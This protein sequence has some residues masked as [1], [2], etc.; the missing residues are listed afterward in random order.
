MY[1]HIYVYGTYVFHIMHPALVVCDAI[2]PH[3]IDI[4]K[5]T[6]FESQKEIVCMTHLWNPKKEGEKG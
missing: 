5:Q 4:A 3:V 6:T 1:I 2:F